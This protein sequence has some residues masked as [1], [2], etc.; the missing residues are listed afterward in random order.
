MTLK[1]GLLLSASGQPIAPV[2]PIVEVTPVMLKPEHLKSGA[3]P[4]AFRIS[5]VG[6]DGHEAVV[7]YAPDKLRILGEH[8]C[9]LADEW[10]A[11][12]DPKDI[13]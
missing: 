7:Y 12:K 1:A 5:L 11:P 10:E 6:E 8:M 13:S 9:A 4:V 2:V 3:P